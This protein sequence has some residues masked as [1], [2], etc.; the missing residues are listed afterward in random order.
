[1][2]YSICVKKISTAT[3]GFLVA[4]VTATTEAKAVSMIRNFTAG[5]EPPNVTEATLLSVDPNNPTPPGPDFDGEPAEYAAA[6]AAKEI[7]TRVFGV[8]ENLLPTLTNE[9]FL[10]GQVAP[11]FRPDLI[12]LTVD[13]IE[14][15]VTVAHPGQ[16]DRRAVF[17]ESQGC[18][19]LPV[20]AN[21]L[22][23]T[24][25]TIQW[26]RPSEDTIWPLGEVVVEGESTIDKTA[27]A[28]ALDTHI[29]RRG[30]HG[31]VVVHQGELVGE[32]YVPGYGAMVPQRGWSTGKSVAATAIGRTIDRGYLDLDQNAPV[33]AWANDER[34]EITIRHLLNMS[35]GLNQ[36]FDPPRS[37]FFSPENEHSFIYVEG[38]DTVADAVEVPPG[39]FP[40]GTDYAYRNANPILATAIARLAFADG[41]SQDGLTFFAREVFEPLGMRSSFV[42]TDIYGNFLISGA[43]YTTARDLARLALVHLQGGVL[44]GTR[45]LSS[46]WTN[47]AYAPSPGF[48]GYG[49][50]WRNNID[51]RYNLPTDAFFANG[52]FGQ[53]SIAIPSRNL[54]I[55]QLAQ[56]GA[57]FVQG[58][59]PSYS[60]DSRRFGWVETELILGRVTSRF[61]ND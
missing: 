8:N 24:P 57:C 29:E 25:K 44:G 59:N 2:T 49:A 21:E 54:V 31:I 22:S 51:G 48:E 27:L 4:L 52:G 55:A 28:T 17:A 18:I 46:E 5:D 60:R 36:Q 50:Y 38:F 19:I 45:V 23:F 35:S 34:Q 13:D 32:R 43:F 3:L 11:G 37:A 16:P 58:D 20:S 47:F 6:W 15:T 56:S 10:L 7:C 39:A 42:E 40:P 53:K 12:E 26:L 41:S 14:K 9:V 33:E 1:M 30:M 61:M